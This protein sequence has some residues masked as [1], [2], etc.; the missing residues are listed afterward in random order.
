VNS[1]KYKGWRKISPQFNPYLRTP[2]YCI[3]SGIY[4]YENLYKDE[5][6]RDYNTRYSIYHI[7]IWYL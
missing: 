7:T 2:T 1:S 3:P 6:E 4:V 5:E